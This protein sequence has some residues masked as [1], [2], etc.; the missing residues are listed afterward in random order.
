ME[1]WRELTEQADY[2]YK[3]AQEKIR[4]HRVSVKPRE[5]ARQTVKELLDAKHTPPMQVLKQAVQHGDE[6]TVIALRSAMH[7]WKPDRANG[8]PGAEDFPDTSEVILACDRALADLA[9]G[10]GERERSKAAAKL[11]DAKAGLETIRFF[12]MEGARGSAKG[13]PRIAAALAMADH[14]TA[15]DLNGG[16]GGDA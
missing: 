15:G 16:D 14:P 12:A 7:Y 10:E 4:E 11:A 1:T 2:S 6:E 8:F 9:I 5:D 13:Q 3:A